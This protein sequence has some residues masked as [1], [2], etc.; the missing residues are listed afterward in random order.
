MKTPVI[1][2]AMAMTAA[3]ANAQPPQEG[4][5]G[6]VSQPS[7]LCDTSAQV[8]SIV[9][10]F[11]LSPDRGSA[12][13]AELF[14]TMNEHREPTC[15][16]TIVPIAEATAE[17][18][19]IGGKDVRAQR[20]VTA[21]ALAPHLHEIGAGLG[22]SHRVGVPA[23]G[24]VGLREHAADVDEL[25]TVRD[26][27]AEVA[28][29]EL[30]GKRARVVGEVHVRGAERVENRRDVVGRAERLHDRQR[31][32]GARDGL[33][34]FLLIL[35]PGEVREMRPR[36]QQAGLLDG[37]LL[38]AEKGQAGFD[39]CG[40]LALGRRR[41]EGAS[42]ACRGLGEL[43]VQ[44]RARAAVRRSR[45]LPDLERA[46]I[47][48]RGIEGPVQDF[49]QARERMCSDGGARVR[50]AVR[51]RV[52]LRAAAAALALVLLSACRGDQP[53]VEPAPLWS[54]SPFEFPVELWDSGVEGETDDPEVLRLRARR[55]RSLLTTLLLCGLAAPSWAFPDNGV[56]DS[57][58]GCVDG[59]TPPNSNWTNAV[60]RGASSTTVD[61]QDQAAVSTLNAN[62][63]EAYWNVTTFGAHVEV[64]ATLTND[65]GSA[66][67]AGVFG[68]LVNIGASTTDGYGVVVDATPDTIEIVRLDDAATT[69]LRSDSQVITGNDK[70]GMTIVGSQICSYF[71]DNGAGWTQIGCT[72]DTTYSAGGRIGIMTRGAIGVGD[73][74]DFGGGDL[75]VSVGRRRGF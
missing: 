58:T 68:R 64:Y 27:R 19:P 2:A 37:G 72:T 35:P 65:F 8:Q 20:K 71:N 38:V 4:W 32:L 24:G 31:L 53:F 56:L 50:A 34:Q 28:A 3:A 73:L 57:F 14:A 49:E 5:V 66:S 54:A 15:A 26:E 62:E 40:K 75:V 1:A 18:L 55:Q 63:G 16:V 47:E 70:F 10:A 21:L 13:F 7:I 6:T 61:C 69:V 59:T 48:W 36:H 33:A 51:R 60:F 45:R 30:A 11:E 46:A 42:P 52:R 39:P 9:D 29:A 22:F 25:G 44:P 12:R 17:L 67:R 74:D 41:L 43:G 23:E